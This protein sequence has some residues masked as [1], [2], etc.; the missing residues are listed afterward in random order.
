VRTELRKLRTLGLIRNRDGHKIS[1]LADNS[2]TDLRNIVELTESGRQYLSR[3]VEYS[4][5]E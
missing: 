4:A 2:K 3:L 1:E 5:Q